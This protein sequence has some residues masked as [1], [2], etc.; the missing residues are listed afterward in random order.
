MKHAALFTFLVLVFAACPGPTD[1]E[2]GGEGNPN[3]DAGLLSENDAGSAP[4]DSGVMPADS[5]AP[6]IDA[7][8]GPSDSGPAPA[9]DSGSSFNADSGSSPA[10]DS[11]VVDLGPV[12][13][14][15]DGDCEGGT[16]TRS[17]PGGICQG[18]GGDTCDLVSGQSDLSCYV[19]SCVRDCGSDADC[20][21]GMRCLTG[22]GR[23]A[24]RPCG[25]DE[26]CPAPY[27]CGGSTCERPTCGESNACPAPLVCSEGQCVEPA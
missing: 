9:V 1:P 18:C 14:R 12:Q 2:T 23:C 11:G 25:V 13:C 8:P 3:Q 16:C 21:L 22:S 10:P 24:L 4:A 20:S 6:A 7:G 19:G 5:G 15:V 26:E 17:A 27:V